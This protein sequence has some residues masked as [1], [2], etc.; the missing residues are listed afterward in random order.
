MQREAISLTR[1]VPSGLNWLVG[2][3]V[4]SSP[5]ESLVFTLTRTRDA[6]KQLGSLA[7][8]VK[9]TFMSRRSPCDPRCSL[10]LKPLNPVA[11]P[12]D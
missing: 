8:C 3:F 11:G 1:D 5:K 7:C 9:Q 4:T 6:L 2:P 10:W 12:A